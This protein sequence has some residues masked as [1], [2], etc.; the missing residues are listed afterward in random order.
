MRKEGE[1]QD[2]N[3]KICVYVNGIL[4]RSVDNA[5]DFVTADSDDYVVFR[6]NLS[7]Y[8]GQVVE[9]KIESIYGEHACFDKVFMSNN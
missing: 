4:I 2:G 7:E 6:Y 8:A 5:E 9:V 1:T 3:P